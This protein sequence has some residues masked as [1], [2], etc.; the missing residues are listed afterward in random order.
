ANLVRSYARAGS[1]DL[2]RALDTEKVSEP[3]E[4]AIARLERVRVRS[5]TARCLI[6]STAFEISRMRGVRVHHQ[7]AVDA[8]EVGALVAAPRRDVAA[9]AA[10]VLK[11]GRRSSL[12]RQ[13]LGDRSVIVKQYRDLWWERVRNLVRPRALSAWIAGH[14]LRVR[15]FDAAEPLALALCG[16]GVAMSGAF[17]VMEDL[18][19][20]QRADLVALARYVGGS[21]RRA[22]KRALV[23]SAAE[24]V[25]RLHAAGVYH[26]DLKA[27]NLFLRGEAGDARFVL[28][29]YDRVRLDRAVSRRR[30][31]KNLAQL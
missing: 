18:G 11:N 8:A 27:V 31:I 30:R 19:S 9:G 25:R 6:R 15:G 28:V 12:S 24:L 3:L 26:T 17:L 5:R 1:A 10:V 16:R 21:V 2:S 20:A 29:D 23:A 7:R 13:R 22:E 14:G 4:R